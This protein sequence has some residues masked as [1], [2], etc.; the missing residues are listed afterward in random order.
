[1]SSEESPQNSGHHDVMVFQAC[2]TLMKSVSQW[3]QTKWPFS[4]IGSD[5]S[6]LACTGREV[7]AIEGLRE[8]SDVMAVTT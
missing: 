4:N 2:L 3:T 7:G 8:G 5:D 1:M 6:S